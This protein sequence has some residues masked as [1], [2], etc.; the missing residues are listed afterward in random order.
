MKFPKSLNFTTSTGQI[1]KLEWLRSQGQISIFQK[2][3]NSVAIVHYACLL[4]TNAMY[5]WTIVPQINYAN[6]L[7]KLSS[8]TNKYDI[9]CNNKKYM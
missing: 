4:V 2:V 8:C 5:M 3:P 9:A 1:L 7:A 6:L